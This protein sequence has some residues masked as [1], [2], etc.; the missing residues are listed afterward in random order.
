MLTGK[1]NFLALGTDYMS[2]FT[3]LFFSFFFFWDMV[4]LYSPGWP[5][6][7]SLAALASQVLRLQMCTTMSSLSMLSLFIN[8]HNTSDIKKV[9]R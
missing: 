3:C 5:Q 1:V 7:H 2:M 6:T 9:V 4:L 8:T